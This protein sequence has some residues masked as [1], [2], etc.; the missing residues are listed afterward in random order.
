MSDDTVHIL[1]IGCYL[2]GRTFLHSA[3]N[4]LSGQVDQDVGAVIIQGHV[5]AIKRDNTQVWHHSAATWQKQIVSIKSNTDHHCSKQWIQITM[6]AY[7]WITGKIWL[8]N[9]T[10]RGT[11]TVDSRGLCWGEWAGPADCTG[12]VWCCSDSVERSCGA[13]VLHW[14]RLAL[15]THQYGR[16]TEAVETRAQ[17]LLTGHSTTWLPSADCVSFFQAPHPTFTT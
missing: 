12:A 2:A 7:Y 13:A 11:A 9:Q 3:Y 14:N 6:P 5:V 4:R 8:N 10:Y 17:S 1:F 15:H 16:S